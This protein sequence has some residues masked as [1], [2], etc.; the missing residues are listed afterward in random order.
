MP[1]KRRPLA[2]ATCPFSPVEQGQINRW[3]EDATKSPPQLF[4]RYRFDRR[5]LVKI[6][7]GERGALA[8]EHVCQEFQLWSNGHAAR[9]RRLQF[10][11]DSRTAISAD[12][13]FSLIEP[14]GKA[15]KRTNQ[16]VVALVDFLVPVLL[17]FGVPWGSTT[18]AKM[19]RALDVVAVGLFSLP[20]TKSELQKRTRE[21]RARQEASAAERR[22]L[23]AHKV[24]FVGPPKPPELLMAEFSAVWRGLSP[25][26][27]AAIR[28]A[29]GQGLS[30]LKIQP[31][32]RYPP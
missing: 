20:S 12:G 11:V 31:P 23:A 32:L 5:D 27:R 24:A 22:L 30:T 21:H 6:V 1:A 14:S 17:A 15:G 3:V 25:A 9:M 19:T 7:G 26:Q 8:V 4:K 29:V 2:G 10:A 28:E 18:S 13:E 16:A